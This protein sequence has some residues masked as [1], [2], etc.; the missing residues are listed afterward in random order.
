MK[1]HRYIYRALAVAL[2]GVCTQAIAKKAPHRSIRPPRIHSKALAAS[3]APHGRNAHLSIKPVLELP[4]VAAGLKVNVF[5]TAPD[6]YSP[7]AIAATPD[8]DVFV[9]IDEYNSIGDPTAQR[10][11]SFI[12]LC[13]D[14]DDD[15]EADRFTIFAK[16]LNICHGMTYV[17]GTLYVVHAPYL[18][19]YRDRN[20]DGVAD[21]QRNLVTGLGPLPGGHAQQLPAGCAM[22]VDGRLYIAV[23]GQGVAEAVGRDGSKVSNPGSCILRVRPDGTDLEL[24]AAGFHNIRDVAV[25]PYLN[26]FVRDSANPSIGWPAALYHVIDG[27]DYGYPYRFARFPD[28]IPPPLAT[29]EDGEA[30][31]GVMA[32]ENWF[33]NHTHAPFVTTDFTHNTLM[34]HAL[35][36]SDKGYATTDHVLGDLGRVIDADVD[37]IG[38][39]YV[40]AWDRERGDVR[41]EGIVGTIY[42]ISIPHAQR[43]TFPNLDDTSDLGLVDHL[44]S[45]SHVLRLNA[46]RALIRKGAGNEAIGELQNITR[47]NYPA[48]SRIAALFALNALQDADANTFFLD[49]LQYKDLI[50]LV[51]TVLADNVPYVFRVLTDRPD[52]AAEIATETFTPFLT[53]D[54][55]RIRYEATAALMRLERDDAVDHVARLLGDPGPRVR[56][57]AIRAMRRMG[58]Y[59]KCIE[60]LDDDDAIVAS[61]ALS[62]LRGIYDAD[63]VPLLMHAY[64]AAETVARRRRLIDVMA[65][66]CRMPGA[67]AGNWWGL[68]PGTN[69]V[70]ETQTRWEGTP[71]LVA[72]LSRILTTTNRAM[73]VL[74]NVERNRLTDM[75]PAVADAA[76]HAGPLRAAAARV[77]CAIPDTA[78]TQEYAS[79]ARSSAFDDAIRLSAIRAAAALPGTSGDEVLISMYNA[80]AADQN[81]SPELSAGMGQA[82]AQIRSPE[83]IATLMTFY[84]TGSEDARNGILA[85]VLRMPYTT[86]KRHILKLL[87]QPGESARALKAMQSLSAAQLEPFRRYIAGELS[88]PDQDVRLA[89]MQAMLRIGDKKAFGLVAEARKENVVLAARAFTSRPA[90]AIPRKT[91]LKVLRIVVRAADTASRDM[92]Q[93]FTALRDY[94]AE[95][96]DTIAVP[97]TATDE[98][99]GAIP[100]AELDLLHQ[101]HDALVDYEVLGP[102]PYDKLSVPLDYPDFSPMGPFATITREDMAYPWEPIR[103]TGPRGTIVLQDRFQRLPNRIAYLRTRVESPTGREAVL[104]VGSAADLEVWLNGERIH[105]HRGERAYAA[106]QD[107]IT[108]TLEPGENTLL[109]KVLN[110]WGDWPFSAQLETDATP[111]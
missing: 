100:P 98:T 38:N 108:V 91:E 16:R 3:R 110:N 77:L 49:L 31:G 14:T 61:G 106:G 92:P 28:E 55:A 67:Y 24:F 30:G 89:A 102:L 45:H 20:G 40:A 39:L 111:H 97:E 42:R 22:A 58:A 68:A 104:R 75:L 82:L 43:N 2:I 25:D 33:P 47:H 85:T 35:R 15:G 10:G 66:L 19:E 6:V 41:K 37:G 62:A 99:Y 95:I 32:A 107:E 11:L 87:Q 27:A 103:A 59:Q 12:V 5:A 73:D 101:M 60:L 8:G 17:D 18:T 53:S 44:L 80:I 46:L 83:R 71:A 64:D 65:R 105:S 81:V 94:A 96:A 34:H 109:F 9:A 21:K 50:P 48:Y 7:A 74:E 56:H 88:N 63:A 29:F 51:A 72:G 54:I 36:S 13:R 26:V 4:T 70:S 78:M 76:R 84:Q 86:T 90:T 1:F 69:R 57:A 52:D 79:I 23:G 93:H